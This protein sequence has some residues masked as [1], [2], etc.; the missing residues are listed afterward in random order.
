[1]GK[2]YGYLRSSTIK[3]EVENQAFEVLNYARKEN[4]QVA[5]FIK[6]QAS[7]RLT[8]KERKINEI[9]NSLQKGDSLIVTE[10][11]RI[12]RSTNEVI[13]T[14]NDLAQKGI[15][16]VFIKQNLKINYF[17]KDDMTSKVMV[18]MFSLFSELERDLISRRTQ[19]ALRSK[20]AQGQV[21]G[22]P[23]GMMQKSVFDKDRNR[24]IELLDLG[25]SVRHIALI[26]LGIKHPSQLN[27]YVNKR[28]LRGKMK[29]KPQSKNKEAFNSI[30]K[31][32]KEL[33]DLLKDIKVL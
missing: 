7:S 6:V 27:W 22:K 14:V 10:L 18:T 13:T 12:G 33:Q 9:F 23:K 30:G 28:G 2:I 15:E 16:V 3:K 21:L 26:H 4:L 25:V 8:A 19:E 1:M 32:L 20:K 24:I 17:N 31:D 11:S 5:D 29:P